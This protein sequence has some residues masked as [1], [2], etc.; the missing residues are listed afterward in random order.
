[1][2]PAAASPTGAPLGLYV[3]WPYCAR[4]C[5]YCD[6]NVVR[7]RGRVA[8][9][10]ALVEAILADMAAHAA[11]TG[12]R[13]LASIFFGGGTPS[14]MEPSDVARVI[15]VART[16]WSPEADLEVSLEANPTDAE[17]S[18]LAI[19]AKI[20][21]HAPAATPATANVGQKPRPTRLSSGVLPPASPSPS[22]R[23]IAAPL[24]AP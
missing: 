21:T 23:P 17:S 3:H 16:L 2:T 18:R 12:P 8:Q 24:P 5:P 20:A 15:A 9:K 7:D 6:F 14:L 10:A 1:M 19:R 11:L 4:I 13:R 22:T